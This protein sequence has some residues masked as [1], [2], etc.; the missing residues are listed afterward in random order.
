[1][2]GDI[3]MSILSR[4]ESLHK[5]WKYIGYPAFAKYLS[6]DDDF[7]VIRRYDRL[8]CRVL[9]TLQ[10]EIAMLEEELDNL[11]AKYSK[12]GA[13][14]VDNGSTRKDQPERKELIKRILMELKHYGIA[15][16]IN[17]PKEKEIEFLKARDLVTL[18]KQP[19]SPLRRLFERYILS[20]TSKLLGFLA[21][22][23]QH[24]GDS[25]VHGQDEPI[26][27]AIVP[28]IFGTAA[29]MLIAPLWA[30][31][32]THNMVAR[33]GIIT[34]FNVVLLAVLTS[35]TLAK[36]FEVLA[37]AA[38]QV[39]VKSHTSLAQEDTN[40]TSADTRLSW[41]YSCKLAIHRPV[42]DGTLRGRI[43]QRR[44]PSHQGRI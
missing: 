31:A 5:P 34:F 20:S 35:A 43:V 39:A 16:L 1:M 25:T 30:L 27:A 32:F 18:A 29:L 11:D 44:D 13:P 4:D 3:E 36:P 19:K 12:K 15:C 9:I 37:V 10:D 24:V 33:L 41:L 38:G 23:R 17:P 14:D 22:H 21:G 2:D 28:S 40:R 7:F 26:D 8:H 42:R 6:L